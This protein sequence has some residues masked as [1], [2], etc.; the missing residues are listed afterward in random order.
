MKLIYEDGAAKTLI[1]SFSPESKQM[2]SFGNFIQ[3]IKVL[4]IITDVLVFVISLRSVIIIKSE[5]TLGL[6]VIFTI[7]IIFIY[8]F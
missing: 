5:K 7:L 4:V 1:K 2:L 6:Y 3:F 8:V